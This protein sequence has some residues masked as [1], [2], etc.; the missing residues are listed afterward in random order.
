MESNDDTNIREETVRKA[1]TLHLYGENRKGSCPVS[2]ESDKEG[3][4]G[5]YSVSTCDISRGEKIMESY[6]VNLAL[7][8]PYRSTRCGFCACPLMN[9]NQS[10]SSESSLCKVCKMVAFCPNC[11]K[12]GARKWHDESGECRVLSCL[13]LCFKHLF[14]QE[15]QSNNPETEIKSNNNDSEEVLEKDANEV[16]STIFLTMRL[17]CRKFSD[18]SLGEKKGDKYSLPSID[19]NLFDSLYSTR[20]SKDKGQSENETINQYNIAIGI[21]CTLVKEQFIKKSCEKN[22]KNGDNEDNE[23]EYWDGSWITKENFDDVLGKVMGCCHAVTDVTLELGCQ[24]L[25]RALFLEHSFYNH[26]CVPN[27]FLSCHFPQI[28][29]DTT[30]DN[31]CCALKSRVYCLQDIEKRKPITLSYIPTSGLDREERNSR[32]KEGYNFAC[33]CEACVDS[34]QTS[35]WE[36]HTKVPPECDIYAI[37]QLQYSCNQSLLEIQV[38]LTEDPDCD[39]G[40]SLENCIGLIQMCS[41]GIE[42]QKIPSSHEVSIEVHRLLATA[43]SLSEKMKES[44]AEHRAFFKSIDPI[45]EIFDPVAVATQRLKFSQDLE[46]DKDTSEAL[47]QL[48]LAHDLC[49]TVLGAD[50]LLTTS[51]LNKK[52]SMEN[53]KLHKKAKLK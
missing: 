44:F 23:K 5:L 39:I 29:N 4:C 30:E 14:L 36:Q 9:Y 3:K 52:K 17:M 42:N 34:D 27:S 18:L 45:K 20:F 10:S 16:D 41:R 13:V 28:S 1:L 38:S 7:D 8:H 33:K 2:V 32:L 11:E 47:S 51:I 37:R 53:Q 26:S 49:S 6:S 12:A 19:W 46:R 31:H 15:G 48:L 43:F 35:R 22:K 24:C 25:G 40:A 21:L 50:H